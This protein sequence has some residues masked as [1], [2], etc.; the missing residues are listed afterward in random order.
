MRVIVAYAANKLGHIN[1]INDI[2]GDCT[3]A[4][5]KELFDMHLRKKN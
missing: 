1:I 2:M 4:I 5:Y 3:N